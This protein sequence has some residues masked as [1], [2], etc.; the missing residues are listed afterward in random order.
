MNTNANLI[1][2]WVSHSDDYWFKTLHFVENSFIVY[3]SI[4][5][6]GEGSKY[7]YTLDIQ[8]TFDYVYE[9]YQML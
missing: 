1:Y 7:I 6:S 5:S 4:I 3:E 9:Y 8:F 2:W